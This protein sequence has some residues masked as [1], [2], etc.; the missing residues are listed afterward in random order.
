MPK[1]KKP[2]SVAQDA[3]LTKKEYFKRKFLAAL[4]ASPDGG[5]FASDFEKI[6]REKD[7]LG[8]RIS[9][10]TVFNYLKEFQAEGVLYYDDKTRKYYSSEKARANFAVEQV[11]AELANMPESM[12]DLSQEVLEAVNQQIRE[13]KSTNFSQKLIGS[14][15]RWISA[16]VLY[17]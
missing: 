14:W 8:M 9:A 5:L 11:L 17:C 1:K 16:I 3:H 12:L 2:L 15:G 7:A 4:E 13:E 6:A 10:S